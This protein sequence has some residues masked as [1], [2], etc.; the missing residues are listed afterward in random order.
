MTKYKSFA[1]YIA[2]TKQLNAIAFALSYVDDDQQY[3]A[4]IHAL[5][6]ATGMTGQ[7]VFLAFNMSREMG[8]LDYYGENFAI[9]TLDAYNAFEKIDPVDAVEEAIEYV[10]NTDFKDSELYA[11]WLEY[12]EQ[13]NQ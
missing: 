1:Q 11:W 12:C 3:F 7:D 8:L 13:E 6:D 4:S 10:I 2:K 5:I 9:Y